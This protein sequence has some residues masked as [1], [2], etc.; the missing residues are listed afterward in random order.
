M[1]DRKNIPVTAINIL[2]VTKRATIT[3]LQNLT[4]KLASESLRT[5][6]C[7]WQFC[8]LKIKQWALG[9]KLS[10]CFSQSIQH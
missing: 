10:I 5:M 2:S 7:K 8:P 9:L 6:S 1:L 4:D 3:K